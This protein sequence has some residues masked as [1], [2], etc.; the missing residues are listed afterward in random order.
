MAQKISTTAGNGEKNVIFECMGGVFCAQ[1][2]LLLTPR[3]AE[4]WVTP[5][6][7]YR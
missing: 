6:V 2:H 4:G 3:H 1:S 7:S 5:E